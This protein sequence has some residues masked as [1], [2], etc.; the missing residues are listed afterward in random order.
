MITGVEVR[1][2]RRISERWGRY[3]LM[4]EGEEELELG[5]GMSEDAVAL[6]EEDD[7]IDGGG[8][9]LGSKGEDSVGG[10]VGEDEYEGG[11]SD[12]GCEAIFAL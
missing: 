4:K 8:E 2:R 9:G 10:G 11:G 7:V 5:K 1:V 12:G 3:L 6:L